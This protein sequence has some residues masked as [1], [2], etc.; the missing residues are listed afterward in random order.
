MKTSSDWVSHFSHNL[1]LKRVDWTIAPQITATEEKKILRSLQAWQLGETSDGSHLIK[2]TEKYTKR[3]NDPDYLIAV[4][5]FIKEEQKHGNNLGRYL[6]LIHRPRLKKDWGDSLFRKV[7]YYNTNMEIWT[8]AVIVV[9]SA[10]EIF[11]K[12]IK[13]ATNCT[14]LKQICIDILKDEAWHIQFQ[15]DRLFILFKHKPDIMKAITRVIYYGFFYLTIL[16]VWLGHKRAFNAGGFSFIKYF[17]T[18]K[19][20]FKRIMQYLA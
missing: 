18:I 1:T 12:A 19:L 15:R 10:A 9:E 5:L 16:I 6:D 3:I 14:L 11:Y 20:K 8:V 13:D 7:R 2:A 17:N 4:K